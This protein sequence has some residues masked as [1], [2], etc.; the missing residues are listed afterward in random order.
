MRARSSQPEERLKKVRRGQ[1]KPEVLE[2]PMN[3]SPE[4]PES[5]D[6]WVLR[7]Q[8]QQWRPRL[9]EIRQ[10]QGELRVELACQGRKWLSLCQSLIADSVQ[11]PYP[12]VRKK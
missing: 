11:R 4:W 6:Q 10:H 5:N 3:R 2:V 9:D 7:L 8:K 1:M 12:Q